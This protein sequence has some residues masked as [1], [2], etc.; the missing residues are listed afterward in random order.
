MAAWK[1]TCRSGGAIYKFEMAG[2]PRTVTWTIVLPVISTSLN[3][4]VFGAAIG[5]RIQGIGYGAFIVPGLV[6]LSLFCQNINLELSPRI[7]MVEAMER[8]EFP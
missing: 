6:V 3:F 5:S 4:V 7:Q 1:C 8:L 2:T